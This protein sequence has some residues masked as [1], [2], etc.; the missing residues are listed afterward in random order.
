MPDAGARTDPHGLCLPG[1]DGPND[2]I[3]AGQ[4]SV[5]EGDMKR[6]VGWVALLVAVR[7]RAAVAKLAVQCPVTSDGGRIAAAKQ[8][9][10]SSRRA[11]TSTALP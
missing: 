3:A 7:D 10:V 8:Q 5:G 1:Q 4:T 6:Y 9:R 11:T 2:R